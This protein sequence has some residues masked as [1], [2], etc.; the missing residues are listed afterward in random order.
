[1]TTNMITGMRPHLD[2]WPYADADSGKIDWPQEHQWQISVHHADGQVS[3][4]VIYKI[5]FAFADNCSRRTPDDA[6]PRFFHYGQ[7][8]LGHR[9]L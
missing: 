4:S 3:K 1:M 6:Q 8:Q 9:P 7:C 2:V 5:G